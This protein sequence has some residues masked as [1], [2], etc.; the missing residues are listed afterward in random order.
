M[1]FKHR[2]PIAIIGF[3]LFADSVSIPA[4]AQQESTSSSHAVCLIYST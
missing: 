3:I 4:F 2:I 1:Q